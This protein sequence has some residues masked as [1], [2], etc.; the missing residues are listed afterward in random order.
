MQS[1]ANWAIPFF[2]A[3]PNTVYPQIHTGTVDTGRILKVGGGE[4]PRPN[5]RGDFKPQVQEGKQF[6]PFT[7][8]VAGC[9][10]SYSTYVT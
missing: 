8:G 9:V 5:G 6:F 7:E 3:S 2:L 4:S 1:G 10:H